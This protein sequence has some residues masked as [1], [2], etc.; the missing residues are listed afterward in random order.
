MK[1]I[2]I[3]KEYI[4]KRIEKCQEYSKQ[5]YSKPYNFCGVEIESNGIKCIYFFKTDKTDN[6]KSEFKMLLPTYKISDEKIEAHPK[7]YIKNMHDELFTYND[8]MDLFETE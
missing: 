1:G 4:K 8:L 3:E 6:V 2:G 7:Y 5:N